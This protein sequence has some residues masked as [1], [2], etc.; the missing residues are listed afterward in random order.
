MKSSKPQPGSVNEPA[1]PML[2]HFAALNERT[3]AK[4]KVA[5][6]PEVGIFFVY[7]GKPL[8]DGTSVS[9]AEPYGSFKGHATGHPA[10]WRSLQRNG[11]V[12]QDVEYDEVPRGRIGYDTKERKFYVF[13]D[14]CI[15]KDER[16]MDRIERDMNLP[17]ADTAPPKLDSHYRCTGCVKSKKEREMEEA[18]W[19]F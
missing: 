5:A 2:D 17:S 16:M 15:K 7:N 12:P 10:F 11:F 9:E 13:A 4:R 6:E 1:Q 18:D 8:I 19:N 3:Q 14:A